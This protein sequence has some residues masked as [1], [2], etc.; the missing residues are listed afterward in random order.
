[1]NIANRS[2]A[3]TRATFF[4]RNKNI[5]EIKYFRNGFFFKIKYFSNKIFLETDFFSK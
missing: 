3:R 1:V 4:S 5:L 2:H